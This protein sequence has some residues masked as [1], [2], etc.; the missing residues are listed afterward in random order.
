MYR[1]NRVID[2]KYGNTIQIIADETGNY[3]TSFKAE[4]QAK[5]E[6]RL[7]Q[8]DKLEGIKFLVDG[9]ILPISNN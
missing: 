3:D 7:M 2:P 8:E 5:T 1:V 4:R 9:E 6:Y